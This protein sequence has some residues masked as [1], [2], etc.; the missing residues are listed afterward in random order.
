MSSAPFTNAPDG[1][2]LSLPRRRGHRK[3]A[4]AKDQ[5]LNHFERRC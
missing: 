2:I 4:T 3:A 5:D 1:D